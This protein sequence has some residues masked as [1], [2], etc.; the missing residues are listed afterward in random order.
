MMEA[1]SKHGLMPVL[2]VV[3]ASVNGMPSIV[4]CLETLM[5]QEGEIPYEVL[6]VDRCGEPTREEIRRRLP[7]P[8]IK[9][10]SMDG[11]PS[12]PR[13]RATG[14]GQVRGRLVAV[15][16]DHC[17]VPP[18]WF[19]TIARADAAGHRVM[20][21]PVENGAVDRLVDW[22]VYFC[23]Y[24]RFM[25]PLPRGCVREIAGNCAIYRRDVLEQLGDGLQ[26]EVW[27]AFLHQKLKEMGIEFYCDPDLVV[28]HKKEF[29]FGYFMS[30][31]YHYS[32]SFAGMRMKG[33]SWPVRLA[34]AC[35]TPLVHLSKFVR[36]TPVIFAFLISWAWGEAVGALFGPGDSL[37]RVD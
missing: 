35:A 6:V 34:Y 24:S 28:Y 17:M 10:I 27:E 11:S 12:I 30:Q 15:L 26:Q 32:R 21:G 1:D 22:A 13:L 23:E 5:S 2:S 25:A 14:M 19:Q 29:G 18:T 36:A 7:Q 8:Q 33:A 20:G 31:R 16:E 4:E 9:L 37:Q 3:I